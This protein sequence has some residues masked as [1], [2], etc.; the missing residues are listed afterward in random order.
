MPTNI[1][2]VQNPDG[3]KG[4]TWNP[5]TG[6]TK[7]SA[8]CRNCYAER[9]ARRLGGRYG[10]PEAP[11]HF[12]VTLHPDRLDQPYHWRKPRKVFVCSMSD[13]FHEDVPKEFIFQVL[14]TITWNGPAY[15]YQTVDDPEG[16][17]W[18]GH[19]FQI[20]TK[21]P[22]R[23]KEIIEEF[24]SIIEDFGGVEGQILEWYQLEYG[25]ILPH[26]WLGVTAEDQETAD[27]RIPW[28]LKTPA[29]VRFVS[30]E[31]MLSNVSLEGFDGTT[32]RP[33]LDYKAWK[34]LIDWVICG[35]ETGPGAREMK[36]EWA[37]NLYRACQQ[38]GVPF[39]FKKPGDAFED[40]TADLPLIREYPKGIERP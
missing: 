19:I 5:V 29:A 3:T 12:R 20:L 25:S 24:R 7:I 13:L 22:E 16:N 30:V 15:L 11:N 8:G 1:E 32:Y 35:G 17:F 37:Q 4:E 26:L 10:Y 33:W 6:C 18:P 28:L 38:A 36:A 31:P 14:S 40:D 2:W 9:M 39:F 27:E 23:M 21:R 34:V